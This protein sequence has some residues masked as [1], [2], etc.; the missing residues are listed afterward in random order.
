VEVANGAPPPDAKI[1]EKIL[2]KKKPCKFH[3]LLDDTL[4]TKG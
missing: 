1:K 2:L 4:V 3:Q